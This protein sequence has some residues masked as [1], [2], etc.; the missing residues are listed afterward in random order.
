MPT[1]QKSCLRWEKYLVIW[2]SYVA[3]EHPDVEYKYRGVFVAIIDHQAQRR[4]LNNIYMLNT[5][6]A[7]LYSYDFVSLDVFSIHLSARGQYI[8]LS[9][10]YYYPHNSILL[11]STLPRQMSSTNT[12][13]PSNLLKYHSSERLGKLH[14]DLIE[15]HPDIIWNTFETSLVIRNKTR[16]L[17]WDLLSL[18]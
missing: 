2:K 9:L 12:L 6:V 7:Y 15:P 18:G 16:T 8:G 17:H 11:F 14:E 4:D 13:T 3:R 5:F 10:A 1:S